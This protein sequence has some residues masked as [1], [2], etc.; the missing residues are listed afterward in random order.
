MASVAMKFMT[1]EKYSKSQESHFILNGNAVNEFAEIFGSLSQ[2]DR[3]FDLGSGTGETTSA[4]AQGLLCNL[5]KP[6]FVTGS[7]LSH[8]M[9]KFCR[10]K[11]TIDNLEFVQLDVTNGEEF[12][13][14]NI[15]KYSLVTSFSCLHWV[16]DHLAATKLTARVLKKGGKFLHLVPSEHHELK[17]HSYRIFNDMKSED[18]W[19]QMLEHV[20]WKTFLTKHVNKDWCSTIGEDGYGPMYA[21]DYKVLMESHGFRVIVA[22]PYPISYKV[23]EE[24]I[25][26]GRQKTILGAFPELTDADR[27]EFLLEYRK[28]VEAAHVPD[29]F[30]LFNL[31]F[32]GF[33]I[34]GEKL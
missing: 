14:Q 29:D 32:H 12:G 20:S 9:I 3:V 4:M 15:E 17:S 27:E 24:F 1:P 31:H 6:G 8:D 11:Y 5:G 22:K 28:R 2:K 18:K 21:D 34:F 7:D 13:E 26:K 10:G 30:G 25:V 33:L 19:K 23:T 16:N